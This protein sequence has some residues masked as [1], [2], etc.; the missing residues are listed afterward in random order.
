MAPGRRDT[1]WLNGDRYDAPLIRNS[2]SL[3]RVSFLSFDLSSGTRQF[4]PL[5]SLFRSEEN[6]SNTRYSLPLSLHGRIVEIVLRAAELPAAPAMT[7]A[8][9]SYD[10]LLLEA[11]Y[12]FFDLKRTS[13][14]T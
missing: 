11:T 8:R 6:F 5:S 14:R 4:S 12:R 13:S 3:F 1:L 9:Q 10:V 7:A 2:F